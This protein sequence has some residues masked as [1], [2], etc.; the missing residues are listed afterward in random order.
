MVVIGTA[1]LSEY[2]LELRIFK[3]SHSVQ[4]RA[5][6]SLRRDCRF[7][8]RVVREPQLNRGHSCSKTAIRTT[9][10]HVRHQG[11]VFLLRQVPTALNGNFGVRMDSLQ[12]RESG[13]V[14]RRF[15]NWDCNCADIACNCSREHPCKLKPV[16]TGT[17][18]IRCSD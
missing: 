16:L 2:T 10:D 14:R 7:D 11:R 3:R 4:G 13:V 15:C 6:R 8:R 9:G 17:P 12:L 1:I 18:A 5:E